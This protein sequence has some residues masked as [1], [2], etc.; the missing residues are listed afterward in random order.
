VWTLTYHPLGRSSPRPP[1]LERQ[2]SYAINEFSES[3][4]SGKSHSIYNTMERALAADLVGIWA[5]SPSSSFA[6]RMLAKESAY[7]IVDETAMTPS[8]AS[9][10]QSSYV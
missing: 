4:S 7:S 1:E 6:E 3:A 8:A 2:V 10:D 9:N 5:S